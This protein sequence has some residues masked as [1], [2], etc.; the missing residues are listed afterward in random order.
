MNGGV[1]WEQ[2]TALCGFA[3]GLIS[4]FIGAFKIKVSLEK[5]ISTLKDKVHE[6]E[7]TSRKDYMLRDDFMAFREEMR[8]HFTR[9]YEKVDK[10]FENQ[11]HK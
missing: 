1:T 2:I 11:H 3:A 10:I 5:E 4:A 8:N 6:N 9:L 7:L